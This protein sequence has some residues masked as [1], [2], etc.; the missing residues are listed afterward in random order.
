MPYRRYKNKIQKNTKLW[1]T[2]CFALVRKTIVKT[3]NT[4]SKFSLKNIS[5][6]QLYIISTDCLF[7]LCSKL[8]DH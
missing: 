4:M 7:M 1:V 6:M 3:H 2:R 5:I 8:Y